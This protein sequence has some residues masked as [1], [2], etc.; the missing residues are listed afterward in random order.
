VISLRLR[1]SARRRGSTCKEI[2]ASDCFSFRLLANSRRKGTT[3]KETQA[4]DSFSFRLLASSR[5]KG[6]TCNKGKQIHA[7][8]YFGFRLRANYQSWKRIHFVRG[9]F[10]FKNIFL[11][12]CG[13]PGAPRG[14]PGLLRPLGTREPTWPPWSHLGHLGPY[15]EPATLAPWSHPVSTLFQPCSNPVPTLCQPCSNHVPTLFQPCSNTVPATLFQSC[16]DHGSNPCTS[17]T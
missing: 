13:W 5:R 10:G 1:A 14:I 16:S 6:T 4:S 7:S 12:G 8:D 9:M 17:P 2:Q 15:L 11:S 3:C